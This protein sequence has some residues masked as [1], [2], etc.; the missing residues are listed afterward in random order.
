MGSFNPTRVHLERST[1]VHRRVR[2]NDASTPR[3]CIWNSASPMVTARS[4]GSFNPTRVHLEHFDPLRYIPGIPRFN[5]TRVHLEPSPLWRSFCSS[6]LQPHEGASGTL[7]PVVLPYPVSPT[8]FNPTRVHL[9]PGGKTTL[10][11]DI[12]QLQPH[13]GASGTRQTRNRRRITITLQPH[14]GASGTNRER[15]EGG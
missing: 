2:R 1:V 15:R 13:E 4:G 12:V 9:E 6:V 10:V 14:E 7:T 5:P 3:G 11:D 8:C